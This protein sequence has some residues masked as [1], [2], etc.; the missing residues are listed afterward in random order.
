MKCPYCVTELERTAIACP[1]CTRDLTFFMPTAIRLS[2][3]EERISTLA[4]SIA[5]LEAEK[6]FGCVDVAPIVALLSSGLLTFTF[7]WVSWEPVVGNE[8]DWLF[9]FLSVASPFFAAFGL[10]LASRT[11]RPSAYWALGL[12]AGAVGVVELFVVYA[13][14]TMRNALSLHQPFLNPTFWWVSVIAYPISGSFFFFSGGKL[15]KWVKRKVHPGDTTDEWAVEPWD[16]KTAKWLKV[17][18]PITGVIASV[19]T[20]L[21][22]HFWTKPTH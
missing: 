21:M 11:L 9:H 4:S 17:I 13:I 1:S 18:A 7:S 5:R 20:T 15:G 14:C 22:Q 2:K 12:V 8:F 3:A 10:G 6:T 16:D 19:I